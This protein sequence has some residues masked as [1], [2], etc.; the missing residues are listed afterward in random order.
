MT[1]RLFC[2]TALALLVGGG[3]AWAQQDEIARLRAEVV[4]QQ[5]AIA[6]LLQRLDALEKKQAVAVTKEELEDEAKT[7]QDSVNSVRE[8]LLSKVNVSGYSNFRYFNDDSGTPSAFQLNNLGLILGKQLGRFSFLTELELQN[9]PHHGEARSRGGRRGS[10]GRR[11]PR[12][13]AEKARWRSRMPGWNTITTATLNVRGGKQLSPQYWWQHRYPNLTYSTDLPI[14]LR[15]LF[16]PELVG[17]MV[18]GRSPG[19]S[20]HLSSAWGIRCTLPTTTSKAIARP[21]CETARRGAAG[22]S[23][24]SRPVG[25]LK[26]FDVAGDFYSGRTGFGLAAEDHEDE[27]E[28]KGRR[29]RGPCGFGAGRR[30]G[31]RLRRPA[32]SQPVPAES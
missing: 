25:L 1:Q 17:V 24:G 14:H 7:Q 10:L 29:G 9:V 6:Q 20:E 27:G 12:M 21:I 3:P 8:T 16:P 11:S 28:G 18:Q 22:F 30:Q 23:C 5:A 32:R 4:S 26:R 31:L 19:R 13:S 2:L 15:E